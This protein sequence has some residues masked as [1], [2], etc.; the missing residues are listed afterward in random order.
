MFSQLLKSSKGISLIS[1]IIL[2]AV[3]V[4]G[5]NAYAYFN[6]D[7][8]L[9]RFSVVYLLRSF[10]DKQRTADLEKIRVA[11]EKYYDENNEYPAND[12][13]C[14]RIVTVLHPEVKDAINTY[15]GQS[16]IPQD[17][18]YPGTSKDYFYRREDRNSFV[19][20]AVL[21]NSSPSSTISNYSDCS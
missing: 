2:L 5:L 13:W 19:L 18:S 15:F 8:A 12:G 17:P 7:F 20:M 11:I 1:I 14:G 21:E 10:N 9:S 16:G 6:P 4:A 3:A